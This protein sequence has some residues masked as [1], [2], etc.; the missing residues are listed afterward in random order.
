[1][2]PEIWQTALR[3]QYG[4]EQDFALE[5]IG[6]EPVFSEFRVTNATSRGHYRVA[7]RGTGARDNYC[8]CPDYATNELGTCK[9]IEFTLARDLELIAGWSPDVV[10]VDEAQRIKN[11]NTI[12]ARALKR[13][14]S[15]TDR[16]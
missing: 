9:H 7:I 4:R 2:A 16:F 10:I 15:P 6:T 13:I 8:S 12:A 5:N 1:M 11:W 3:R 14:A